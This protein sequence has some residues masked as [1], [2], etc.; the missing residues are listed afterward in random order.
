MHR[1]PARRVPAHAEIL[2]GRHCGA[3]PGSPGTGQVTARTGMQAMAGGTS[4]RARVV[5]AA[6]RRNREM[7]GY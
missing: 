3:W 1:S 4:L 6:L 7:T 5:G 2:P